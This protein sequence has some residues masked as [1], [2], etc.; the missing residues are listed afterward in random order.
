M[1][2]FGEIFASLAPFFN[3]G[4]MFASLAPF[5][6]FR[7]MFAS[8]VSLAPFFTAA[9]MIVLSPFVKERIPSEVSDYLVSMYLKWYSRFSSRRVTVV[10]KEE[11]DL[12]ISNQIYEAARVH[13]R[14]L[15]S[16]PTKP[17]RF[18]V[19]KEDGQNESTIDIVEDEEVTDIFE[20]ISLKWK[21]CADCY[22][23]INF[24]LSFD[25]E[26]EKKVLVLFT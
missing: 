1:F 6:N 9:V 13:L 26:F 2:T 21:L 10:I 12:R 4:E 23:E 19:N 14:N 18:K 3:F 22:R 5:F 15:I 11:G 17:K 8:L 25:M 24:E 16:N 20:G 7:E